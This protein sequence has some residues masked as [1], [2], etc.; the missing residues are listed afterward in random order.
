MIAA[1][2]ASTADLAQRLAD[3]SVAFEDRWWKR[4]GLGGAAIVQAVCAYASWASSTGTERPWITVLWSALFAAAAVALVLFTARPW[5]TVCCVAS[6]GL[7]VASWTSRALWLAIMLP[8]N[9]WQ[10]TD[11]R[12]V[13]S[14]LGYGLL[15]AAIWRLWTVEIRPWH[16]LRWARR[17]VRES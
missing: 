8:E 12:A 2:L 7:L 10:S 9:G 15:A 16:N 3:L 6:G 5:C 1:P 14:V 4:A 13:I 17:R 11:W